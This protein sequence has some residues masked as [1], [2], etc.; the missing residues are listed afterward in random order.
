MVAGSCIALEGDLGA[1]KTTLIQGVSA[2]AGVPSDVTVNSPTF[3]IVN[4]YVG[5]LHL[6]HIDAYRLQGCGAL[7]DLGFA[8]MLASG[9]A[10][11][12]EWADRVRAVLPEDRLLIVL[13]HSGE[14]RRDLRCSA[15]GP[16]SIRMIAS[17]SAAT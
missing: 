9:G 5:R 6:Y 15:S 3:V 12:V 14:M 13:S 10:V 17:L 11:L 4:E 1:G 8:E 16:T 2:G 7:L